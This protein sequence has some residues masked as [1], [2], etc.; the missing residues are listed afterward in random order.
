MSLIV[1]SHLARALL[2]ENLGILS[3]SVAAVS[4]MIL[5]VNLGFDVWLMREVAVVRTAARELTNCVITI[6][7]MLGAAT[8][9][10][11]VLLFPPLGESHITTLV[12]LIQGLNV[13]SSAINLNSLYSG[14]QRMDIVATR[15]LSANFLNMLGVLVLVHNQNDLVI[16]ALISVGATMTANVALMGRYIREF[17]TPKLVFDVSRLCNLSCSSLPFFLGGLGT[18]V[19]YN[20]HFVI[21]GFTRSAT[22]VGLFSAAWKVFGFTAVAPDVISNVFLP[23]ISSLIDRP[24]ERNEAG[25]IYLQAIILY[26]L[27]VTIIGSALAGPIIH[28]LFGR[29]YDSAIITLSILLINSLVVALNFGFATLMISAGRQKILVRAPLGGAIVSIVGYMG[30]IPRFG[31][32]GAAVATLLAETVILGLL[33]WHRP[34]IA[35]ARIGVF[36][37]RCLAAT[38]PAALVAR[39]IVLTEPLGN[40]DVLTIGLAGA[41]SA[42]VYFAMLGAVRVDLALYVNS[43]T[44][45]R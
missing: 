15:E 18:A 29:G 24:A 13:F 12:V 7:L 3:F 40:S 19:T 38:I 39:L 8:Y 41:L 43:L 4:Y 26:A 5:V 42:P 23:R 35:L 36:L 32:N 10:L 2:A 45:M 20:L 1:T 6:R 14:L 28:V 44:R 30:L 27:P 17:G 22:E 25:Q 11:L 31:P 37:V 9:L 34:G 21:L 33:I 16:A